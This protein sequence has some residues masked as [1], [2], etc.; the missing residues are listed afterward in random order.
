MRPPTNPTD[1]GSI[2][3][4]DQLDAATEHAR[5]TLTRIAAPTGAAITHGTPSE[6]LCGQLSALR[7]A[8][9]AGQVRSC[10]HLT[11]GP[12]V[13]YAAI[14]APARL[15]CAACIPALRPTPDEE[16]R[17]DRCRRR[18]AHL[19][20]G[21]VASGPILLAYGLC[22][23]C[24]HPADTALPV[25]APTPST[26]QPAA[27]EPTGAHRDRPAARP[28]PRPTRRSRRDRRPRRR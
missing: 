6:W 2:A 11:G 5:A 13:A 1:P 28:G 10:V 19:H 26:D 4:I 18:A 9:C 23:T 16:L 7:E 17:C 8:L 14:W 21:M 22:D 20:P 12:T 3:F 24:R 25:P 27:R 15:V